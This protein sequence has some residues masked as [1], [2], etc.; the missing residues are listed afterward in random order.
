MTDMFGG[1]Y[2]RGYMGDVD[3]AADTRDSGDA[4]VQ[5]IR[6]APHS[7]YGD[8]RECPPDAEKAGTCR[9]TK[10]HPGIDLVGNEGQQVFA[11]SDGWILYS[12]KVKRAHPRF[13]NL[14]AGYDPNVVLLAHDDVSSSAF[15]RLA[16]K[17]TPSWWPI[18]HITATDQSAVYS[19]MAHLGTVAFT[20]EFDSRVQEVFDSRA[21]I[22]TDNWR[23]SEYFHGHP[24]HVMTFQPGDGRAL[25]IADAANQQARYVKKGTPLG[26]IGSARHV[27]WEI[28]TTPLGTLAGKDGHPLEQNQ[29]LDPMLWLHDIKGDTAAPDVEL[30]AELPARKESGG[31]GLLL[32]L[33][34]LAAASDNRRRR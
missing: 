29:R 25:A 28:R 20:R 31:G 2:G 21:D 16:A 9:S 19:L 7:A 5:P 12:G 34:L 4:P 6:I 10:F 17:L 26:N 32:L 8:A 14:F 3:P 23:S 33:L 27:H 13:P 18:G 30:D 15:R 1:M 24:G 11:P 22:H